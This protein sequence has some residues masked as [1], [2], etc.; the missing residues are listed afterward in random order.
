MK[1]QPNLLPV[2]QCASLSPLQRSDLKT[3][4][5]YGIDMISL[6]ML[7]PR[8]RWFS[9][10]L[11]VLQTFPFILAGHETCGMGNTSGA[12]KSYFALRATAIDP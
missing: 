10:P 5:T 6:V 3:L 1:G 4:L 9:D 12:P 2:V 8:N 7:G 11:E